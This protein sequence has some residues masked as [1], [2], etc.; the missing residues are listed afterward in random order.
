MKFFGLIMLFCCMTLMPLQAQNKRV[1]KLT[2][3]EIIEHYNELVGNF[4]RYIEVIGSTES[5]SDMKKN[6]MRTDSVPKLFYRY[7]ERRMLL[8]NGYKGAVIKNRKMKDYFMRL[9]EQAAKKSTVSSETSIIYNLDFYYCNADGDDLGWKKKKTYDDGTVEYET[10]VMIYQ[11]Y[12][13]QTIIRG[14]KEMKR[15]LKEEDAKELILKKVVLP[16]NEELYKLGDISRAER[17]LTI[18]K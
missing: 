9:Q 13:K 11:T 7:D 2:N 12:M 1:K 4:C 8:T 14:N 15:T 10:K 3:K 16:G 5:V 6:R 18:N 17:T